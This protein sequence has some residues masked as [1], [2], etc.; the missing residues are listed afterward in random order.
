MRAPLSWLRDFAPIEGEPAELAAAL[1]SLGL[2]VD[3]VTQVGRGLDGVIVAQVLATRPH[4]DADRVQL[5]DVDAGDGQAVQV[6]CGAF[7]FGTGDL[8]PLAPVGTT[9]PSGMEI[10]RRRVRG[11]WSEGML[12]SGLELELS[13][14]G[15][16]IM[17][18]P[19][20]L[21]PGT[22]LR[23][24]LG[25][26][27]DV[28]FD[29]DV[30]PN[31]PDALAMAGVARDLAAHLGVPFTIPEVPELAAG[32]SDASVVVKAKDLCPRFT[33]QVLTNVTVGPSPP[34]L[35]SRLTLAGMRSINNVVDVSNYVMLE[36]GQPNHPYDL[37]RLSGAG[38]LIRRGRKG[39]TVTTLDGV[40]RV[41][42]PEDCLICDADGVPVGI[43]GVMGGA[44]A[45]IA[46]DTHT[47]LLESAYFDPVAIARTA[48][49][50][51]LRTEAS[52]RFERGVDPLGVERA[53]ARFCTL[54]AEAAGARTAGGLVD[55]RGRLPRPARP[56]VRTKRVNTVLGTELSADQIR[57]CLEPIGFTCAPG[58]GGWRVTI[59]SWRPDSQTEIDVIEEVARHHG[60]GRIARTM[61]PVTRVGGLTPYQRRRRQAREALAGAGLSEAWSTTFLAPDDLLSAGLPAEAVE[62]ENPLAAE[63][64]VLR[65]SVLPGLLRALSTNAAHRNP[66]VSL[67][68]VGTVFLLPPPGQDLPVEH[69]MVAVAMHRRDAVAARLVWDVLV[70]ALGV[71]GLSLEA[72]RAPGLH[73]TRTA[74][75]LVG[76]ERIGSV[77]EVDP[78][79]VAAHELDD[80]VGWF[81]VDLG[82]LLDAPRRPALYR[83][84]SRYPSSDI[85]LAFV[86]DD[87]VAA[88]AVEHTLREAGGDLLV[89]VRLFDVFRGPQLGPG[90][91]SLAY[92]LRFNALDHTLT[93][94]EVGEVRRRCI[95]AVESAHGAQLRG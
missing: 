70:G 55:V 7:N 81:E 80:R 32:E 71:E 92:R 85:D 64:S 75:V 21:T 73:P 51:G 20:N 87:S 83:P 31:R 89:D 15:E 13:E 68:E 95:A 47:V 18:L 78:A 35:A 1:D 2:V 74:Q 38:L 30:T 41:V 22:T 34:W 26:E 8:V 76:G 79:V 4:P 94:E 9:L 56:L 45:E 50:V 37:G 59:P 86:V 6:V 29:L 42:G 77:G 16:G 28:V 5:V 25:I 54:A 91:R 82:R 11:Q 23:D 60:Y 67:F 14:D 33:A 57:G 3:S 90:R 63:E 88:A 17:V 65:T 52:V 40:E 93:D 48:K 53:A 27:G 36:L 44:I 66:G 12:C 58:R 10:G 72:G 49:R 24:A 19:R 69:E 84:I 43:G 39:E 62:V 61:P 46:P